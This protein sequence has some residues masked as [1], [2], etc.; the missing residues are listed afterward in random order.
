MALE[1]NDTHRAGTIKG[2]LHIA[3]NSNA[4]S[5]EKINAICSV[6]YTDDILALETA[7]IST[8][9]NLLPKA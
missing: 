2:A 6:L 5:L 3:E 7:I 8:L 4:K 1:I 9:K